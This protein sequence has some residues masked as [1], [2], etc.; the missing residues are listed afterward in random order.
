METFPSARHKG[1]QERQAAAYFKT[2]LAFSL[3]RTK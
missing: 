1:M 2:L 3:M